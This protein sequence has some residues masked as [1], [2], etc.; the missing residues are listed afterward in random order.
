MRTR[1]AIPDGPRPSSRQASLSAPRAP[2]QAGKKLGGYQ[3]LSP[4]AAGGM[5]YVWTAARS[6]DYGFR[7]L[8]AIKVMRE[9]IAHETS[10]RRMFL[11][12][13][14]LAALIRHTHVVEVLELGEEEGMVYQV[15][16]LIEGDSLA[17]LLAKPEGAGIGVSVAVRIVIDVL[18]GLHAAHEVT[19]EDGRRIAI[20]HR[21]VSPQ[22]I[23]VGADG[24]S[25]IADF[26]IA[27][28]AHAAEEYATDPGVVRGKRAY[29]S[30][31]QFDK[32]PIDH[33][34]DLFSVGVVLWE[35]LSGRHLEKPAASMLLGGASIDPPDV[36]PTIAALTMKALAL[37]PDDRFASADAMADG[38]EAAARRAGLALSTK[39]VA[40]WVSVRVTGTLA[41]RREELTE[42]MTQL[43]A[44][45]TKA[46][47]KRAKA[48]QVAVF[49]AVLVGLL[50]AGARWA[51]S[52]ESSVRPAPTS[53]PPPVIAEAPVEIA[54]PVP[55]AAPIASPPKAAPAPRDRPGR[56]ARPM[57]GNPYAH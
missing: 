40:E 51:R 7:R 24:I 37:H 33:R 41:R 44:T 55:S 2:L 3:L 53:A 57:F 6:G 21:D 23:L 43:T 25:K 4:I 56:K 1:T 8:F 5:A 26:G 48:M 11:E 50:G 52:R 30:P 29:M 10:F 36:E 46:S 42:A 49:A 28:A 54:P 15:M 35:L 17:R 47:T 13:A 14:K 16:P 12:E 45:P 22:N 9:E 20:V 31:E 27:K 18:R 32:K 19:S 39:E 38:L 34:S